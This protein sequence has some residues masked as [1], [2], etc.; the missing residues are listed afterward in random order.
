MVDIYI[1]E[2]T[3]LQKFDT[4]NFANSPNPTVAKKIQI[5]FFLAILPVNNVNVSL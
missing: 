2:T 5:S 4:G 3:V 1:H